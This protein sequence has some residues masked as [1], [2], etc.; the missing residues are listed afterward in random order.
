LNDL[1]VLDKSSIV[2]ELLNGT[3][4]I[5]TT[6]YT[7]NG[8][9]RDWMYFLVDGIYPPGDIFVTTYSN[10]QDEKKNYSSDNKRE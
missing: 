8:K 2:Y 10:P 7:I 3:L 6:P 4:S 5:V 1:N 9:E